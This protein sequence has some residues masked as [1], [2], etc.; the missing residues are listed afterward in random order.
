MQE[1]TMA[2]ISRQERPSWYVPGKTVAEVQHIDEH[3]ALQILQRLALNGRW[4]DYEHLLMAKF[5]EKPDKRRDIRELC[6][7]VVGEKMRVKGKE[8]R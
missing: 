3:E 4:A 2:N 6:E 7:N 5:G 1:Q 8:E